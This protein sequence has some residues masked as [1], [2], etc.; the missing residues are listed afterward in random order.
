M[1]RGLRGNIKNGELNLEN[2]GINKKLESY[3][4][5][6]NFNKEVIEDIHITSKI[7]KKEK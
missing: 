3:N 5:L 6:T 2:N 4:Y 7:N 1:P